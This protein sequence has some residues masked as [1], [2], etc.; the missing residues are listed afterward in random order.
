VN[1]S[2]AEVAQLLARRLEEFLARM[3]A[4][5]P[6]FLVLLLFGVSCL[7]SFDPAAAQ[8]AATQSNFA[9]I[10]DA[11]ESIAAGDLQKA[12]T[13]LKTVLAANPSEFRAMSLLGVVRAQQHREAEA[14]Q[15]FK[16]AIQQKPDFASAHVDLGLLY[17][18]INRGSDAVPEFQEAL[19]IDPG[20]SD[21][22]SS[23]LNVW[24]AQARD[25][26][27][28]GDL[29]KALA[30]LIQAHKMAPQDA[31][32]TFEFGMV[33]L[34]MSLLP[35]AIQAFQEVLS[36]RKDDPGAL[37]GLGR[38]QIELS[39]YQE[40]RESFERYVQ[41]RPKDASGHYALGF[42]LQALQQ[43]PEAR[44]QFEHSIELQ[45]MQTESY[46][47]LGLMDLEGNNLE[48]AAS[49]FN[50]VLERDP[51][52]AGALTGMGRVEFQRKDY[53]KAVELLQSAIA[54]DPSLRE[55]HYYLGMSYARLGKKDDSEKELQLASQLEHEEVEKRR[56]VIKILDSNDPDAKQLDEKK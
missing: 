27:R 3:T 52:H 45:P 31:D 16:Q 49:R 44:R 8:T 55:A 33:A 51:K 4:F 6:K 21:A 17:V 12:E 41:L 28:S 34:R 48:S 24:R 30:V 14:E 53:Q 15:L 10:K 23:L 18:Q 29:E 46:F 56:V 9:L 35:D 26:L 43:T 1:P 2:D 47:Q 40:A 5:A 50:R 25:A 11:A 32:G 54:S 42:A 20:R 38:A 7:P 13:E 36:V 19:R 37:Y 39:K 22:L